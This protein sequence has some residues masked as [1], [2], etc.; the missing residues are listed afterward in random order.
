MVETMADNK[1][2][3]PNGSRLDH[4]LEAALA[5]YAAVEPRDGLETRILANLQAARAHR[6]K[7]SW[8]RWTAGATAVVTI[9]VVAGIIWRSERPRRGPVNGDP[10]IRV[11]EE[12]PRQVGSNQGVEV[13]QGAATVRQE[14]RHTALGIQASLALD[15]PKLE[16]F[17]SPQPLSEQEKILADYVADYPEHAALIARAWTEALRREAAEE[18]DSALGGEDIPQQ[19]AR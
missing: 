12:R 13:S 9:V 7:A 19:Q 4:E 11:Q 2:E 15:Q 1:P 16:Q 8:W 18:S 3:N 10:A 14:A 17:P 6:A 5:K